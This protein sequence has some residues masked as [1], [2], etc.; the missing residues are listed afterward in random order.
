MKRGGP[1]ITFLFILLFLAAVSVIAD[2]TTT[3]YQSVV[4]ES[5]DNPEESRWIAQGSKFATVVETD[6]GR[7]VY[8]QF[9]YFEEWPDAL[10]RRNQ[11]GNETLLSFGVHGKFNRKGYN[12]VEL[13]PV[14]QE[15]DEEGKPIPREV[16]L[17]GR[18][19]SLDLW[20]WGANL[21]YYVEAHIRDHRG[22]VHVI[23]MGDIDY[24]GWKNLRSSIPTYI[25]QSVTHAPLFR[26]LNLVKLVVW[27]HPTERVDDFYIYFDQLKI[28][29]DVF[30][31]LFDGDDLADPEYVDQLWA[32]AQSGGT[33]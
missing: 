23:K 26:G 27:T 29:T 2:E 5:F 33:Q 30:E 11:E 22:I 10:Y 24:L 28:F 8:P 19:A 9:G 25:P 17:P 7:I 32:N 16:A 18:V 13:I 31:D 14:E 3:S 15:N 6:E 1:C 21:A 12:Y 20:V 4:V